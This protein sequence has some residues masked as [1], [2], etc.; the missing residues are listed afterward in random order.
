MFIFQITLSYRQTITWIRY[1]H[2][3]EAAMTAWFRKEAGQQPRRPKLTKVL[4]KMEPDLHP[5][6][7]THMMME[8]QMGS[9]M[10]EQ[11]PEPLNF[12]ITLCQ[13]VF[14][15]FANWFLNLLCDFFFTISSNNGHKIGIDSC[16]VKLQE[17]RL[18]QRMWKES[19]TSFLTNGKSQGL[20]HEHPMPKKQIKS[21]NLNI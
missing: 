14:V 2:Q 19:K 18:V 4:K 15:D 8:K 16:R 12:K 3:S 10:R 13:F 17:Q 1:F 21:T 20:F 11:I 6:L 7:S 5:N 9:S